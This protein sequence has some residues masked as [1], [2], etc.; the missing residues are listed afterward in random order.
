[1][2]HLTLNRTDVAVTL[3]RAMEVPED[4]AVRVDDETK[5]CFFDI[6]KS[7]L[8]GS[9]EA[10]LHLRTW[11]GWDG[12]HDALKIN[13]YEMKI[14]GKNHF[15]D[16]DLLRFPADV[17]KPGRNTF[18]I[19]STTEHHMLEVLWPGPAIVMRT[20]VQKTEPKK[21]SAT[22]TASE[23]PM[24]AV[25]I[26][27]ANYEERP[28][29]KI[30][31]AAATY[32]LDVNSGGLSR[33]ID[34]DGNDWIMFKKNPWDKYPPSAAS[35]FR[36][37]P[38]LVF[39]G[40]EKGFGHPGWDRGKSKIVDDDTVVCVSRSGDWKLRWDFSATE[41]QV[42]VEK[43]PDQ[44]YW[45]L[46]EGPI[47]GRWQPKKQYFATDTLPPVV[48]PHDFFAND[49]LFGKWK[50]AYFG[51]QTVDRVLYIV[52]QQ[53]DEFEDTFSHLGNSKLGL[54]SDD[55][56]VVFGFGRGSEGLQPTL[57]GKNSFR[58]G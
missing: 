56:M 15:Y 29:L 7:A 9:S 51:D 45:F 12:H 14:G 33:L 32:W 43:A 20:G 38:N 48:K 4:F 40:D 11:H 50:W 31:T 46:Y 6:P 58:I 16:Y 5:T 55:G 8:N 54:E 3:C 28:H 10:A 26:E 42:T 57:K 1:V 30:K 19:H 35:S 22:L 27:E 17:L 25:T 18:T 39:K 37:I 36:G 47:A 34:A 41:A 44:P 23:A 49:K 2:S 53:G 21:P 24:A 52:H 13:D